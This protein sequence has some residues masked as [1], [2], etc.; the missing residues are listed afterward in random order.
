MIP[1]EDALGMDEEIMKAEQAADKKYF[2]CKRSSEFFKLCLPQIILWDLNLEKSNVSQ[3]ILDFF[4]RCGYIR[5]E[6]NTVAIERNN[7]TREFK[8]IYYNDKVKP[9]IIRQYPRSSKLEVLSGSLIGLPLNSSEI[10]LASRKLKSID[11]VNQYKGD[12]LL[13]GVKTQIYALTF[14]YVM[15]EKLLG[16][17]KIDKV[18]HGKAKAYLDPDD[19]KWKLWPEGLELEDHGS[20]EYTKLIEQQ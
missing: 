1:L 18:F 14:S 17:P 3:S 20:S 9:Y 5:I 10:L 4:I 16:L 12:P 8:L 11:Y 19:G 15:E 6:K 2:N 7:Q 13:T